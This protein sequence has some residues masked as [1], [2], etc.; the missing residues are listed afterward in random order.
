MT[1]FLTKEVIGGSL[2]SI[3]GCFGFLPPKFWRLA[4]APLDRVADRI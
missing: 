1:T 3:S 4:R 2:E